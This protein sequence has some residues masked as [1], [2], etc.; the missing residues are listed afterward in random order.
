MGIPGP[1]RN[2]FG[3]RSLPYDLAWRNVVGVLVVASL[4]VTSRASAKASSTLGNRWP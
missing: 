1:W 4:N 3:G 2:A